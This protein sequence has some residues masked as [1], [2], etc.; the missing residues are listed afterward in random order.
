[1]VS[2]QGSIPRSQTLGVYYTSGVL[3]LNTH[4]FGGLNRLLQ[5]HSLFLRYDKYQLQSR[6]MEG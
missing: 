5:K 3:V 2:D 6:S 1:M 4:S